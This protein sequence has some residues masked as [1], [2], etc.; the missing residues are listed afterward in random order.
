MKRIKLT[1]FSD[2][3]HG[4]LAVK[5]QLLIDLNILD[6]ITQCSYQKGKTVYLEEDCDAATFLKAFFGGDIPS[7]WWNDSRIDFKKSYSDYSPIRSYAKF[8]KDTPIKLVQ[9]TG[10]SLYG[11]NFTAERYNGKVWIVSDDKGNEYKLKDKQLDEIRA[12]T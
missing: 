9:G 11:Q 4:W 10:F 3:G 12:L 2:G 1:Q 8:R 5:R 6:K 7:Q